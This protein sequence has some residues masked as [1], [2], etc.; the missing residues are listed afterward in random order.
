MEF[1]K[2]DKV[3]SRGMQHDWNQRNSTQQD[4][5]MP[6]NVAG[7]WNSTYKKSA[8]KKKGLP[9]SVQPTSLAGLKNASF[10]RAYLHKASLL[11]FKNRC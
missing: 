4:T 5:K 11:N 6:A 8:K 1:A 9:K 3:F 2:V 7:P 10:F